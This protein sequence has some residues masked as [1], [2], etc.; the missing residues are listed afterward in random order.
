MTALRNPERLTTAA[1][2]VGEK[3]S[4]VEGAYC[5]T[6]PEVLGILNGV[7]SASGLWSVRSKAADR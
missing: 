2:A 7:F 6:V 1:E 3:R 4:G 5:L